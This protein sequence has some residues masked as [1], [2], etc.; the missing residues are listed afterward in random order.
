VGT[1]TKTESTVQATKL[2][3]DLLAK[4][5]TGEIAP[6]ELDFARAYLAG[7]Y[8]I[9]SETAERVADRILTVAEFDLPAD[10]NDSYPDLIRGV[11]PAQARDAAQRY[12]QT[13]DLDIVLAGNVSAFRE[14]IKKEFPTAEY[15]EISFD[16]IDV[17]A[18]DLRTPK[19]AATR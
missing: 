13:K 9:Q 14:G 5:S 7:V 12:M 1:F 19:A 6:A 2:V 18:P 10:Y 3:V 11:S 8:P 16:Q 17:L 15:R 4:M